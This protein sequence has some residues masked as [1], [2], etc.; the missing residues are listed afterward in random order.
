MGVKA[1]VPT[2]RDP[3]GVFE[4]PHARTPYY[5]TYPAPEVRPAPWMLR[6]GPNRPMFVLLALV[7]SVIGVATLLSMLP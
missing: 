1:Y 4:T 2:P 5:R 6:G 7:G 3:W